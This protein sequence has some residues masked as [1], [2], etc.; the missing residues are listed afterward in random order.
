[1]ASAMSA[2]LVGMLRGY[3]LIISPLLGPRCRFYP[4]CS[5]YG[6]EAI[7]VH[8]P[9]KGCWLTL[10]RLSRCHPLGGSGGVDLVPPRSGS[11][12]A[13]SERSCIDHSC[14]DRRDGTPVLRDTSSENDVS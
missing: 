6:L 12:S 2:V 9:L 8:G 14:A 13:S 7:K 4:S 5:S 3:Q 11:V 1:M 10:K